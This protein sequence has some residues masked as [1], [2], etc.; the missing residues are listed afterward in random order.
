MRRVN[1]SQPSGFTLVEII[2]GITVLSIVLVSITVLTLTSIQANGANIH[3]LTAYYL[4][5]EGVEGFRN[6]RDSNG[7]QNH[8]W[9]KGQRFW[10]ADFDRAGYYVLTYSSGGA[11]PWKLDYKSGEAEARAAGRLDDVYTRYVKVSFPEEGNEDLLEV[12]AVVE[13]RERSRDASVEVSTE[14]TDWR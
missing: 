3:R 6:M 5:Q 1:F 8:V 12:T 9:N 13:W 2:L 4:A 14:L 11:S 7:R 10:G